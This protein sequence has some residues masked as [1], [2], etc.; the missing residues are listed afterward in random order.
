MSLESPG[1]MG[2]TRN[3]VE[4]TFHKNGR[5]DSTCK[6]LVFLLLGFSMGLVTVSVLNFGPDGPG[7]KV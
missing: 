3:V 1:N 2:K 4:V 5:N 7:V 6:F